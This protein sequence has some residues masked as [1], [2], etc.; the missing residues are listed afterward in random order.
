MRTIY[1]HGFASGPGSKKAAFF[2][3]RLPE[4]ELPDLAQG[5]FEHI[6]IAGQ[7]RLIDRLAAG[8][9]IALIW[10]HLHAARWL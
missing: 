8:Q 3:Q 1:L 4:M 6:T 7:L 5:D 2:R 10:N 9:P